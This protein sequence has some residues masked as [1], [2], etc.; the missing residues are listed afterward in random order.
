[1]RSKALAIA[2]QTI[3]VPA[4]KPKPRRVPFSLSRIASYIQSIPL[5]LILGFF[6]LVPIL[7]SPARSS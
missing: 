1:M 2:E 7:H 6:L 4:A 5:W 3:A